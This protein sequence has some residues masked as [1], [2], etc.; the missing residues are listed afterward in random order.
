MRVVATRR[1]SPA[2]ASQA[3]KASRSIGAAEKLVELSCSVHK[4]SA[5]YKASI[6]PSKH[7]SADKRWVRW[8]VNPVRPRMKAAEKAKCAGVIRQLRV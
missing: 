2:P 6:I 3:E 7:R 1:A 4:E 8:K 5:M